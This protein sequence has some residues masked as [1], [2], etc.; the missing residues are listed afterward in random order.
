MMLHLQAPPPRASV[1]RGLAGEAFLVCVQIV[2]SF[3]LFEVAAL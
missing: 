1:I 3:V 2:G